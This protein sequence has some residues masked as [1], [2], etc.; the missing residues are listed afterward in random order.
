VRSLRSGFTR[1]TLG[2][3]LTACMFILCPTPALAQAAPPAPAPPPPAHEGSLEFAFIGTTGNSSTQTIGLNG[4]VRPDK[5]VVRNKAALLRNESDA[6]LT[7]ESYT[8][9]FRSE[10]VLTG[11]ASAF[12]EYTYLRD[13]FAGIEHHNG[14]T[15]GIAY[16]LLNR[17]TH[18]V[19]VD[20]GL[21]YL[22]EQRQTG[23]DVSSATYT[24]GGVYK[25]RL[26]ATSEFSEDVRLTGTFADAGDWRVAN[27]LAVTARLTGLLS[28]KVS[29]T[30][31]FAN[32][33]VPGFKSTDTNTAIA[34]VAK[35]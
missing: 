11:R 9:L 22:N 16:K 27:A 33:P 7:A 31:R 12:A 23:S 21:G 15:G 17:P 34:L 29:N 6:A 4:E 30:I 1:L 18:T 3:V 14:V 28:L 10:R 25:W 2:F 35:F 19:S 20:G 8:Y 5:W 32:I 13:E 26:S 24:S